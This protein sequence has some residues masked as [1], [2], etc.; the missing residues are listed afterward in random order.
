MRNRLL[1]LVLYFGMATHSWACSCLPFDVEK[2]FKEASVVFEGFISKSEMVFDKS[3]L[4]GANKRPLVIGEFIITKSWKGEPEKLDGVVTHSEGPACGL[5]LAPAR[6]YIFFIYDVVT[7]SSFI[8]DKEYGIV[9]TCGT[10]HGPNYQY[11]ESTKKWLKS[12]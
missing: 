5:E 1:I 4:L 2:N 11:Y 3:H 9:S 6:S 8:G 12:K 10:P 7:D